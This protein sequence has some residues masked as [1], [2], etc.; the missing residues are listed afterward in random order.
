MPCEP[1][2]S[3][4]QGK[5]HQDLFNLLHAGQNGQVLGL[6]TR[7]TRMRESAQ[8]LT[9]TLQQDLSKL[10][11]SWT[12]EASLEFHRR[13]T[14]IVQFTSWVADEFDQI[15]NATGIMGTQLENAKHRAEPPH[16]GNDHMLQDAA[17]NAATFSMFGPVGS[18][19]AGILGAV[20]GHQ[21]DEE[22]RQRAHQRMVNLVA[23]LAADYDR[24][25]EVSFST[26]LPNPPPELPGSAR[27]GKAGAAIGAIV[28]AIAAMGLFGSGGSVAAERITKSTGHIDVDTHTSPATHAEGAVLT[29]TGALVGVHDAALAHHGGVTISDGVLLAGGGG[30]ALGLGLAARSA[31]NSGGSGVT[32]TAG[33]NMPARPGTPAE[34]VL[35]REPDPNAAVTARAAAAR[36]ANGIASGRTSD[37]EP[38]EHSTWLTEDNMDWGEDDAAE[39]ILGGRPAGTDER[40]AN[41]GAGGDDESVR[42]GPISE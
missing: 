28:G 4:Y 21:Q 17:S 10:T 8:E 5:S 37:G 36:P 11:N 30:L 12:G 35:G 29:G 13:V 32:G 23:D 19:A 40:S 25:A 16:E 6:S 26:D 1:Y 2:L 24:N 22:E 7:W 27:T 39:P 15:A 41:S 18:A 38:E 20:Q 42:R 31:M 33:A 3:R 14:S 9:S 34:A